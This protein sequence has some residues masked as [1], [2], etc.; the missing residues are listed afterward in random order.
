MTKH[1]WRGNFKMALLL[2]SLPSPAS[3]AHLGSCDQSFLAHNTQAWSPKMK[4]TKQEAVICQGLPFVSSSSSF[5][6]TMFF[7]LPAHFLKIC[8][9]WPA[10]SIPGVANTTWK[11]CTLWTLQ[12]LSHGHGS[13]GEL[14]A[15]WARGCQRRTDRRPWCA[16]TQTCSSARRSF[17]SSGW[18]TWWKACSS[19]SLS[20]SARWR[21][22]SAPS[23]SFS[24]CLAGWD[25]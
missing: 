2:L 17:E 13:E 19:D 14:Y 15:P 25:N 6:L 16:W 4:Q 22:R 12:H 3:S 20:P 11:V 24:P 21:S 7:S 10:C 18:S 5:P 23:G 9:D 1:R 8:K